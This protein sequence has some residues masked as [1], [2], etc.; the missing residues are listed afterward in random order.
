MNRGL[1]FR[2]DAAI[3][4]LAGS[5]TKRPGIKRGPYED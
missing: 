4:H 1:Y 5:R 3:S 2:S